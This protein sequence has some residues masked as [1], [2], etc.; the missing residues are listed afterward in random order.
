MADE[1]LQ[2]VGTTTNGPYHRGSIRISPQIKSSSRTIYII[3][4]FL[5]EEKS[6][7]YGPRE[8]T[9]S[10]WGGSTDAGI[11]ERQARLL[12]KLV[13]ANVYLVNWPSNPALGKVRDWSG[14]ATKYADEAPDHLAAATALDP[15]P[16]IVAPL[17]VFSAVRSGIA[18]AGAGAQVLRGG[19][20]ATNAA[21]TAAKVV[22]AL[23]AAGFTIL[24]TYKLA[25]LIRNWRTAKKEAERTASELAATLPKDKEILLV[26]HSL[27][28]RIA[29]R[30]KELLASSK[31]DYLVSAI[32]MAPALSSGDMDHSVFHTHE[33]PEGEVFFSRHD[34]ILSLA[35][36]LGELSPRRAIGEVGVG[37]YSP[38]FR[39][40][41]ASNRQYRMRRGH[42]HYSHDLIHLLHESQIVPR[43]S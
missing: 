8:V 23:L 38:T 15:D 27:G 33:A 41:D 37:D 39:G 4:G 11:W 34:R 29:L 18:V 30:T 5:A 3:P 21:K 9:A 14:A 43:F 40:V 7:P 1:V 42:G 28:G 35:Y 22:A 6:L 26:G 19:V 24:G 10:N 12:C 36:R 2:L 25:Q 17:S 13:S 20:A 32:A 16:P 31:N